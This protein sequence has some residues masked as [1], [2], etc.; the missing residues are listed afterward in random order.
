MRRPYVHDRLE[1]VAAD[2]AAEIDTD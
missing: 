2:R 1:A